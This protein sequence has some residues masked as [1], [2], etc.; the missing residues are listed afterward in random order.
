MSANVQRDYRESVSFARGFLIAATASTVLFW[1]PVT[2][3]ITYLL[4]N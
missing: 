2:A 4:S 1:A 3:G